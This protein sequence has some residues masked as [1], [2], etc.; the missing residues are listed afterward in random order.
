MILKIG[1]INAVEI[2]DIITES[3]VLQVDDAPEVPFVEEINFGSQAKTA[4][5]G[6]LTMKV[7]KEAAVEVGMT[8]W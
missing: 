5:F 2:Y 4:Q 1:F 8:H 3:S 7:G 6:S